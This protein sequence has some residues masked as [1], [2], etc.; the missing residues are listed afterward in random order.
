MIAAFVIK[1]MG[2][3]GEVWRFKQYDILDLVKKEI[4]ATYTA[5]QCISKKHSPAGN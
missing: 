3:D 5:R 2:V 4:G 1:L